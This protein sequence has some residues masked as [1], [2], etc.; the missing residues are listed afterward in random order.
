MKIK[1]ALT[2]LL[3]A[4]MWWNVALAQE[5]LILEEKDKDKTEE[6]PD[7]I[8]VMTIK[9]IFTKGSMYGH[10]R[11]YFMAT[12]NHGSLADNYAN[13]IG[14]KVGYRTA[15]LHGFRFGFAG[16]VTYNLFSSNIY[17]RDFIAEKHPKLELELFDI[18]EPDNKMNLD[19]L[20]ELYMEYNADWLRAKVGR[21]NFTSP[22]INPQDT[23]MM[24]YSV[25]GAQVQLPLQDK[26]QVTLAWLHRFSPRST[27]SWFTTSES[28]GISSPGVDPQ[29]NASGYPGDTRTSGVGVAGLQLQPIDRLQFESWN[30]LIENVSNTTYSKAVAEI[31]PQVKLGLEGIYQFQ[32][33]KGGNAEPS[34]AY[35][36]D[37]RQW[38]AGG[39]LAY[40]PGDWHFSANYL[41]TGAGG[42]FLFPRE[43]GREQFFATLSRGRME[44]TG[45][46]NLWAVKARRQV[47]GHFAVEAALARGILPSSKDYLHNKYSTESY[48]SWVTDI[49]YKPAKPILE[50]LS[51]RL[52]YI[53]RVSPGADIPLKDMYYNTNYHNLNFVTQLTF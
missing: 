6:V 51:F 5:H 14:A 19:R 44:G 24:P 23:R 10:V 43:W 16:L 21:F 47:P 4:T 48:W 36:P 27:V 31:V 3:L 22:L 50:G 49:N 35:F 9:E 30:Y 32:V 2:T 18:Q 28:L 29:G 53:G 37:Q 39:M 33:G 26:G 46:A 25:Q 34:K 15:P 17:E 8:Q 41:H 42:R 40:E 11:N 7:T 12:W 38:V 20:D 52:L 45:D 13:A 1:L